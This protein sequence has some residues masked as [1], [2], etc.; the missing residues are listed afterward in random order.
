MTPS[1]MIAVLAVAVSLASVYLGRRTA[2]TYSDLQA[3]IVRLNVRLDLVESQKQALED[4]MVELQRGELRMRRRIRQLEN[5]MKA[6]GLE[7][8][9]EG[10]E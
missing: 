1:D 7:I 4:E 6:A 5:A 10:Q 3:E 2:G 8:P 9:I